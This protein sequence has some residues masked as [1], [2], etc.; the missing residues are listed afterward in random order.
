[1]EL[2]VFEAVGSEQF[3]IADGAVEVGVVEVAV[4]VGDFQFEDVVEGVLGAVEVVVG[5]DADISA[6]RAD[7]TTASPAGLTAGLTAGSPEG[8]PILER[9]RVQWS[10]SKYLLATAMMSSR[11]RAVHRL[12]SLSHCS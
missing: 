6:D 5:V 3:H 4:V 11:V 8:K 12:P 1:M 9:T 7:S 10:R 2:L